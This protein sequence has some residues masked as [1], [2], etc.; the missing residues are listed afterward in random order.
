MVRN[1]VQRG[2]RTNRRNGLIQQSHNLSKNRE[3]LI[4]RYGDGERE[5]CA[6]PLEIQAALASSPVEGFDLE[7]DCKAMEVT[8]PEF[9]K[10]AQAALDRLIQ[11]IRI[12]F[13]LKP[14]EQ[15]GKKQIGLTRGECMTVFVQFVLFMDDLKKKL[16][17]LPTTPSATAAPAEPSPTPNTSAC[18]PTVGASS[19]ADPLPSPSVPLSPSGA[20]LQ[21]SGLTV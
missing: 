13:K 5:V 3:R 10:Q 11:A 16:G 7:T 1:S 17:I 18:S 19:P 9:Q 2:R 8:F 12:A 21:G 14:F 20:S 4:F 6:D 15:I